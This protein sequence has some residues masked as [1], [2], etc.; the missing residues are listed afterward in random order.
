MKV[1]SG[2][3]LLDLSVNVVRKQRGQ[4]TWRGVLPFH[5]SIGIRSYSVYML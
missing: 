3:I 4:H 1:L 2:M 5:H